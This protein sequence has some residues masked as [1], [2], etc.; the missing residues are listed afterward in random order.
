MEI[1]KAPLSYLTSIK[2]I[3]K[4]TVIEEND[5]AY[6]WGIVVVSQGKLLIVKG[7]ITCL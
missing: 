3:T 5:R 6:A 4:D 2:Y 7:I 1:L